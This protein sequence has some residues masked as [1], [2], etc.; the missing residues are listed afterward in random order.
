ME[1]QKPEGRHNAAN[2]PGQ[3]AQCETAEFLGGRGGKFGKKRQFTC[4]LPARSAAAKRHARFGRIVELFDRIDVRRAYIKRFE[5]RA[6][7]DADIHQ[8]LGDEQ[9]ERGLARIGQGAQAAVRQVNVRKAI[10]AFT[11]RS[12]SAFDIAQDRR[13][14]R[15]AVGGGQKR[16]HTRLLASQ[17]SQPAHT[18]G[19]D[20]DSAGAEHETIGCEVRGVN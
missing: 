13:V 17:A 14:Y 2:T 16:Q 10:V 12:R 5:D 3:N 15:L 18:V 8:A 7:A 11:P 20:H 9:P 6:R 4:P 1:Q 19:G